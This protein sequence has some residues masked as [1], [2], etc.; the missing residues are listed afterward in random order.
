VLKGNKTLVRSIVIGLLAVIVSNMISKRLSAPKAGNAP[1]ISFREASVP[2]KPVKWEVH[3]AAISTSGRVKAL[4]R[5]ELFSEVNGILINNSFREGNIFKKGS[6]ILQVDDREFSAQLKAQKSAFM[7]LLS[8]VLPDISI[9]FEDE[10]KNWSAFASK[11]DVD[12][13]LP[14]IPMINDSKLKAFLSGRNVL[15]QYYALKSQEVRLAKHQIIAPYDGV[16]SEVS[17]Q[18]GSLVR[19]GQR[20]GLFIQPN[21]FE[22]EA[23]IPERELSK[24]NIGKNVELYTENGGRVMGQVTRVN[25]S[26]DPQTQLVKIYLTVKGNNVREG[27]YYKF[28]AKGK[29]IVNSIK[30]PRTWLSERNTIFAVKQSDSTLFELP[31]V[32]EAIDQDAAIISG[33]D[34]GVWV[35]QRSVAGAFE[36]MKVVPQLPKK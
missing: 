1:K 3:Q 22:L 36:G 6:A 4:N 12:K 7:G 23:A 29:T 20:L 2:V 16:L 9:D 27:Q 19:A 26:V 14:Q 28:D 32:L 30:I 25:N 13:E 33:I 15:N 10:Y 31:V 11:I 5:F 21:T 18:P 17:I 34:E 8:Q 35:L 24:M